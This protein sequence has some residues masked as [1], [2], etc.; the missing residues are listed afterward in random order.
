MAVTLAE[1]GR[2]VSGLAL[3]TLESSRPTHRDVHVV[4]AGEHSQLFVVDGS[5][6]YDLDAGTLSE[7]REAMAGRAPEVGELLV[8]LG[9]EDWAD[10]LAPPDNPPVRAL[11]LAV[12]QKCNLGCTYCYAEQGGFGESPKDMPIST[13]LD[14]VRLLLADATKG[15]R[16]NLAFMG[17][18]PL[19]NRRVLQETTLFAAAEAARRGVTIGFS[20]TTNG[21]LLTKEDADF[22]E[23]HGF[24]VTVSLDGLQ[25]EHDR[26]RPFVGGAGSYDLIMRRVQ[27]LLE[28]QRRM[29]VSA[30]VTVTPFNSGLRRVLDHFIAQGFHSVGFSPLLHAPNGKNEMDTPELRH[31]LEEMIDCGLAFEEHELR[32]ERYPFLNMV[33]ALKE[34]ERGTHRP[35]PCGAGVGY[36]GVSADGDL[37]ACHRFVGNKD[38]GLG[39]V[40]EGVNV[41]RRKIWLEE[42]HVAQQLPCNQCWARYLCGG[43]CHHEVLARGRSACEYIRGWLHYT[44]Q[45]HGRLRRL[46]SRANVFEE[47]RVAAL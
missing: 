42:R 34:L 37:A 43:G 8:G 45:A 6:L 29:Q 35:Y 17:G 32:G 22:F 10:T 27:P 39:S 33:N 20:V 19:R 40:A 14:S 12:A 25:H 9:V 28:R 38:A 47:S 1:R 31:M 5:R 18:E 11:S 21:T 41:A 46:Q 30:R 24:A 13:S 44:I 26:L 7:V 23:D 3:E 36:F 15:D 16:V 4:S 2:L